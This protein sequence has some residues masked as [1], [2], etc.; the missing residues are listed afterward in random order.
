[1]YPYMVEEDGRA[2]CGSIYKGANPIYE[3]SILK[4]K[5]PPKGTTF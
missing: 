5:L 4:T 1:M 3:G 2:L